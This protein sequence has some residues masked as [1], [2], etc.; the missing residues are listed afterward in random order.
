M[1]KMFFGA[2]TF[3]FAMVAAL[4]LTNTADAAN[5]AYSFI[6]RG[7]ITDDNETDK[8]IKVDITKV[9]GKA[10][11]KTDLEGENKE[12]KVGTAKVLR[13]VQ[14]K[15]KSATYKTLAIGQEIGFKGVKK[16]DDTFV[17]SFIR[18]HERNFTVIGTLDA[19]D[20]SA[21]TLTVKAINSTYKP[22]IYKNGA[23]INMTYT[24]DIIFYEK[25]NIERAESDINMDNQ[26]VKLVGVIKNSSTWEVL[27]FYNK[28]KGNK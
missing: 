4:A 5:T 8:T 18:I 6:A 3:A 2:A 9:D 15:D 23:K 14:G 12:L 19:L 27:K 13:V 26:R 24:D 21:N 7:T 22:T 10:Q 20:K 28:H 11:A 1:K 16:D 17:L 25:G